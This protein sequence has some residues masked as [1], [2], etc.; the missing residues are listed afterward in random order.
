ALEP[1]R[2]LPFVAGFL[3]S[4]DHRYAEQAALAI[5]DSRL[6]AAFPILQAT[7]EEN[8][9]LNL[10]KSLLLALALTRREEAFQY[11][12]TLLHEGG[13]VALL[14]CDALV[15]YGVDSRYRE[16]IAAVVAECRNPKLSDAF[17]SHFPPGP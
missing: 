5:G 16:R 4:A 13:T 10:R 2:S 17:S 12:L 14:A 11:L 8:T 1:D 15:L 6:D 3:R 7:W 9:D